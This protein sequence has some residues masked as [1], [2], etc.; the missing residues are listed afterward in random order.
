[1][2]SRHANGTIII[3]GRR[4]VRAKLACASRLTWTEAVIIY[5]AKHRESLKSF[6]AV[7][8]RSPIASPFRRPPPPGPRAQLRANS[9]GSGPGKSKW[10]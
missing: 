7:R 10:P 4:Q 2:T 9:C 8:Q 1:V 3:S 6:I 5:G